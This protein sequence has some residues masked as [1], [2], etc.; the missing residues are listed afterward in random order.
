[1]KG[2]LHFIRRVDILKH[3]L[4]DLDAVAVVIAEL[5]KRFLGLQS[6]GLAAHG[7]NLV[8][9]VVTHHFAHDGLRHVP[10][11]VGDAAE[12]EQVFVGILDAVLDDPLDHRDIEVAGEHERFLLRLLG[13]PELR[14]SA[15][16]DRFEAELH[17]ELPFVR[18]AGEALYAKGE[19]EMRPRIRGSGVLAEALDDR[20]FV[21][22]HL[23]ETREKEKRH[24]G[25]NHVVAEARRRLDATASTRACSAN[26]LS[27]IGHRFPKR[28]EGILPSIFSHA[29]SL[30]GQGG[31]TR[32]PREPPRFCRESGG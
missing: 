29:D 2:R 6:D 22:R 10:E 4:L 15:G 28:L 1:M 24:Q 27:Q 14:L 16:P 26:P 17:L 19:P 13:S 8:D 18:H 5:L 32:T 20:H 11:G 3:E 31:Q 30:W 21:R 23:V 25:G 7:Q 12:V 9:A